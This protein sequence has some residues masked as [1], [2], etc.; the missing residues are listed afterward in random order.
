MA[1]AAMNKT[2]VANNVYRTICSHC[3]KPGHDI[4]TCYQLHG[5]PKCMAQL[6]K[7]NNIG[8]GRD[9]GW[10]TTTR[11]RGRTVSIGHSTTPL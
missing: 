9:I 5:Y 1:F 6:G 11:G 10:P 4:S 2:P 3:Q 7:M 8:V